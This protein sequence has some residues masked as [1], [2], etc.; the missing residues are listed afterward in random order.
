[1][2][3]YTEI[4]TKKGAETEMQEK[5]KEN[6]RVLKRNGSLKVITNCKEE[7]YNITDLKYFLTKLQNEL[8]YKRS[9]HAALLQPHVSH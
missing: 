1:M 4:K 6:C 9:S 7:D 2:T 5:G 3:K 8:C